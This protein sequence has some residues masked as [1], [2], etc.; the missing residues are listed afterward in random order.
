MNREYTE[1]IFLLDRSGSMSGLEQETI[2]GY[3]SFIKK[4]RKLS[5]QTL[6]TTVLFDD[7]VEQLWSGVEA[8]KVRLT[9]EEYFV[10]GCTALMDAVGKTIIEVGHRLSRMAEGQRPGKVIFVITTDG[11]ENA[12]VEFSSSQVKDLINQ[13]QQRYNWEFIFLGANINA[14]EE[15]INIG[16]DKGSAYQFEASSKGVEAMYDVVSEAVCERRNKW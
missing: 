15:A 5:G 3:N 8:G 16:I 2:G 12:S 14:A 6:V 4:Q 7:K 9:R 11:M 1:I 10:R 13:Q